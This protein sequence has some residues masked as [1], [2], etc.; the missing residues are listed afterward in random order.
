VEVSLNVF[1]EDFS[2]TCSYGALIFLISDA[3]VLLFFSFFFLRHC[4]LT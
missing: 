1:L 2:I 4:S 3:C